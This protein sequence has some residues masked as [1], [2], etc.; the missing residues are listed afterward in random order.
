MNEFY[1]GWSTHAMSFYQYRGGRASNCLSNRH[2]QLVRV[3]I[4]PSDTP[5]PTFSCMEDSNG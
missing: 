1:G 3:I 5:F 4:G 2:P